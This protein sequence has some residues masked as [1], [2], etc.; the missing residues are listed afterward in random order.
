MTTA[1]LVIDCQMEFARRTAAGLPRSN[2]QAEAR[3][4]ETLALFRARD[5][6]VVHIHH[7]DPNPKSG[8]RLG[9]PGGAVMPCAAPLPGEAC[10]VK[11]GSSA[12]VGTGLEAHLR[13]QGIMRIVFIGAAIN[14][15]VSSSLRM[16]ANLGFD[17][18]L[19]QD[20]VFGFGIT[21]PDGVA[22]SPETVLS[23]TLGTLADFAGITSSE[24]LPTQL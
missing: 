9:T 3:I 8:F 10:F 6:P 17:V 13:D 1:L 22:H 11:H 4:A 14:Y 18:L 15:C 12:F 7:D 19:P 5:L 2:P 16:A 20:A 23:V 24:N 21:G